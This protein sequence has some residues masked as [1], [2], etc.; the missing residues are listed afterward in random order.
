MSGETDQV[1]WRGVQ[2]AAGVDGV[3]PSIDATRARA[4][5]ENENEGS[6]VVYTVPAGKKL[7]LSS[8]ILNAYQPAANKARTQVVVNNAAD[9]LQFYVAEIGFSVVGQISCPLIFVPALE[10]AAGW[11]VVLTNEII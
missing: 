4:R 7:Y 10:L 3:W 8:V 6:V 9:V 1:K 11:K 5:G 2:P